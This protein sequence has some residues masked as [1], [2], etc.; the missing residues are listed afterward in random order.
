MQ[1]HALKFASGQ[2]SAAS[3]LGLPSVAYAQKIPDSFVFA[4]GAVCIAPIV[5]IP[6]KRFIGNLFD[7]QIRYPTLWLLS[8][9]E[10]FLW[11][12]GTYL[13]FAVFGLS[14]GAVSL[15]AIF[16]L[17]AWINSLNLKGRRRIG[18]GLLLALP[19]PAIALASVFA[20]LHS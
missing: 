9:V 19:S 11:I 7:V 13:L 6:I 1:S 10:W 17:S 20:V 18:L 2:L 12:P 4:A 16:A 8:A 3:I 5:A 15:T 14:T